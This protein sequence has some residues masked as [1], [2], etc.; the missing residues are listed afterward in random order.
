MVAH[1][2]IGVNFIEKRQEHKVKK[3][4]VRAQLRSGERTLQAEEMG[5][6]KTPRQESAW[7]VLEGAKRHQCA[8]SRVSKEKAKKPS[9]RGKGP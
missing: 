8:C 5:R 1:T 3:G 6:A 7:C 4:R 2:V 9:R